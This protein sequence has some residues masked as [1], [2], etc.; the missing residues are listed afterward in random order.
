MR[1]AHDAPVSFRD[2]D[3]R[4]T[5]YRDKATS[6]FGHSAFHVPD[7]SAKGRATGA[8]MRQLLGAVNGRPHGKGDPHCGDGIGH[9]PAR[10]QITSCGLS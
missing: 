6:R 4:D 7:L 8:F 3:L 9:Q 2:V 10:R 5:S 1:D